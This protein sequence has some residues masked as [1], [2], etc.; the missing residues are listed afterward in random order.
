MYDICLS[1][2]PSVD[3]WV[4][5]IF[6]LLWIELLWIWKYKNISL[7]AF[8]SVF[9]YRPRGGIARSCGRSTFLVE[10]VSCGTAIVFF[11]SHFTLTSM[12]HKDLI[13]FTF[14]PTLTIFW[15]FFLFHN[16]H[17]AD[18]K[19]YLIVLLSCILL[20]IIDLNIFS[21]TYWPVVYLLW[22]NIYSRPVP[23][24]GLGFFFIV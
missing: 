17:V 12:M 7:R 5:S 3:T 6:W 14:S 9:R 15:V 10:L 24:F 11:S 13:F 18:I 1:I 8:F 4:V 2:H 16:G 23:I 19:W 20:M 21:W 22:R